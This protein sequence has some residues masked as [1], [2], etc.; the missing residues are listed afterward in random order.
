MPTQINKADVCRSYLDKYPTLPSLTLA[1]LIYKKEHPLF[2]TVE[3]ARCSVQR[4]RGA[5]EPERYKATHA[6]TNVG[7]LNPFS[8][9]PEPLEEGQDW[10][11]YRLDG[12]MRVAIL[13]D[14]HIPYQDQKALVAALNYIH[15]WKPSLIL[16]NGDIADFFSVSF[17]EKDPRQRNFAKERELVVQFL[18]TLREAFP[19]QTFIYKDGN[20]EDRLARYMKIKAPELL[21]IDELELEQILR[22][23]DFRITRVKDNRPIRLGDHLSIVHGHEFSFQ[24]SSPVNPA[25]GFYL[26]AKTNVLGGHLHRTSEH[27]ER[28]LTETLVAAW[29]AGCLC[30]LHPEYARINNWNHGFALVELEKDSGFHIH[31]HKIIKG[32]IY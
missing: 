9:L 20:H 29:S 15:A 21:G 10:N 16:L 11:A 7:K 24:I 26:K 27:V 14:I 4:I 12:K 1:K 6:H 23:A 17:W 22:F 28:N 5:V 25:R 19:R 18:K 2:G 31:N 13:S 3:A 8:N 32:R 30:N